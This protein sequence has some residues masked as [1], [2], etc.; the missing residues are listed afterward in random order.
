MLAGGTALA[1]NDGHAL[2]RL[3]LG[4]FKIDDDACE[5]LLGAAVE[6]GYRAV[7]TAAMYGNEAGVGRAVRAAA[8][9]GVAVCVTTKLWNDHHGHDAAFRALEASLH[10]LGLSAIDLYLIHWPQPAQDRYVDTWR[11]LVAM[12]E[13]GRVRSIGVSNFMPEHLERIIGET[14]VVPSVNQVELHPRFQQKELRAFH[15]RHEIATESWAPLGRG[16]L[17]DDPV[18]TALAAKHGRS[19]AQV[20]IRWHL[21]SGLAVIPKSA[22]PGRVKANAAVFDFALDEADMAAIEAMDDPAGRTG[23][24]PRRMG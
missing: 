17:L 12:R 13:D 21:Q 8:E 7:D 5:S 22:D 10:R 19:A 6:A 4:V 16:R 2:P 24:D 9:R 20:V 15:A 1:L 11:A 23:P 3:G 14:G 18:L